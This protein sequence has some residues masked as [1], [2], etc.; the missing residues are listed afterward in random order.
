MDQPYLNFVQLGL[1]WIIEIRG[2][3]FDQLLIPLDFEHLENS[4]YL[5]HPRISML[6]CPPYNF[7]NIQM[8]LMM[9]VQ[10]VNLDRMTSRPAV[11]VP[12]VGEAVLVRK[13]SLAPP[14]DD[15]MYSRL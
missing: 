11:M 5:F 15:S 4:N 3:I 6:G 12:P 8:Y 2:P 14:I 7:K 13:A 9:A 1:G 10:L